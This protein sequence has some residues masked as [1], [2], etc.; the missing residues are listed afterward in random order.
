MLQGALVV[1]G[2]ILL[3]GVTIF[4]AVDMVNPG[5]SG[6]AASLVYYILPVLI[7]LDWII[8]SEKGYWRAIEPH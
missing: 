6:L 8:F 7:L 1:V 4:Y 5:V 2:M 3:A